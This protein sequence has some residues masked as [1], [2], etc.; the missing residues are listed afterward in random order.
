M[1]KCAEENQNHVKSTSHNKTSQMCVFH[2][3][4][5]LNISFENVHTFN[6]DVGFNMTYLMAPW[7]FSVQLTSQVT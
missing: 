6:L 3:G 7:M 1:L 4:S 2:V 5:G